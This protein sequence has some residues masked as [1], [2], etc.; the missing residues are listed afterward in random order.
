[1]PCTR[2]VTIFSSP[3]KSH[4]PEQVHND[5][6]S[7]CKGHP[8]SEEGEQEMLR[9]CIQLYVKAEV[10]SV[11]LKDFPFGIKSGRKSHI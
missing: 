7:A 5:L 6:S 10:Q 11:A 9:T 1:M 8:W 4:L 2:Y 3:L